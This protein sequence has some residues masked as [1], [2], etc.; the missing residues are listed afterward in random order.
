MN[1]HDPNDQ[2][3]RAAFS[4]RLDAA[5]APDAAIYARTA[6]LIDDAP[7]AKRAPWKSAA[8]WWT[9]LAA[10]ARWALAAAL[11]TVGGT[12]AFQGVHGGTTS[13]TNVFHDM[14]VKRDS[15]PAKSTAASAS[16]PAADMRT[17]PQ[18]TQ[19]ATIDLAVGNIPLTI[20]QARSIARRESA[21]MYV[22]TSLLVLTMPRANLDAAMHS[23]E[24]L[25]TVRSHSLRT[26]DL[27]ASL[28]SSAARLSALRQQA[29]AL[30]ARL[31]SFGG[32]AYQLSLLDDLHRNIRAAEIDARALQQSA[33]HSTLTVTM[34]AKAPTVAPVKGT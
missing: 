21:T 3:L 28:N 34:E 9:A 30:L 22:R 15:L 11:V 5:P 2:R 19:T 1:E 16:S 33:T 13:G 27:T 7:R 4:A 26:T 12:A 31:R 6:R 29:A 32:S 17:L 23:I 10:P 24:A 14:V 20:M 8:A 25:G 18:R